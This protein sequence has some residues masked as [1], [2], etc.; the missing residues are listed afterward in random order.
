VEV[1]F[2]GVLSTNS[3]R[4]YPTFPITIETQTL[5][6]IPHGSKEVEALKELILCMKKPREYEP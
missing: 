2:I 5:T 1:R 3:K 6:N 4:Y